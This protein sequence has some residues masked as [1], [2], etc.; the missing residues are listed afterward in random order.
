M[1][2]NST[3]ESLLLALEGKN[4]GPPPLW[5]MRQAGRYL[6]EYRELRAR[7][8]L[9]DLFFTPEL[10]ALVTKMPLKRFDLDAAILFSDITVVATALGLKLEF[11]EGPVVSPEV[12][13]HFLEQLTYDLEPLEPMAQTI[14]LL[15]SDLTVPLLGFCGAPFTVASYLIGDLNRT[16]AW[17]RTDP[18]SFK[19][20]LDVIARATVGYLQLQTQAGV[21]A[22]QIFDSWA[23]H[24]RPEE[25]RKFSLPYLKQFIQAVDVPAIFFMRGGSQYIEEI[26]C[27]ISLDSSIRMDEA[28]KQTARP[29]QGNLDPELLFAPLSEIERVV[30]SLLESMRNDP[31]FILN[32]GHGI[33]P[34]TPLEAVQ[35]LIDVKNS[36]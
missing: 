30:K 12:T 33:K 29:L 28:R 31:A 22:V 36:P 14:R 15:K 6:P 5:I 35:F 2:K 21:D 27:A 4:F 9:R 26:P 24:L 13:P 16:I 23:N 25:F 17:M 7:H 18:N 3:Q 8:T 10:A 11:S 34:Q 20:F 1:Q 32:L 19:S